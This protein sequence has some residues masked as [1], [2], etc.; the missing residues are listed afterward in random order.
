VATGQLLI[1][2]HSIVEVDAVDIS[3]T[4]LEITASLYTILNSH[5]THSILFDLY[6]FG[7]VT[8]FD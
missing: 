2:I 3:Y 4:L 1:E 7:T 6:V 8:F 5:I